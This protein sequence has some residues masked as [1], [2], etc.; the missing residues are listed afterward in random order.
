MARFDTPTKRGRWLLFAI[1]VCFIIGVVA[2]YYTQDAE[3]GATSVVV[4]LPD[5]AISVQ[6]NP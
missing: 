1:V 4:A 2:G 6:A 5:S 3:D